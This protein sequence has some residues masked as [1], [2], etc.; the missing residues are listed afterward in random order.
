MTLSAAE[1]YNKLGEKIMF[2]VKSYKQVKKF[3]VLRVWSV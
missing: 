1:N 3:G 2:W